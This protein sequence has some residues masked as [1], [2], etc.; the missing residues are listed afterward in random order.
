MKV[1]VLLVSISLLNPLFAK[2]SPLP[3]GSWTDHGLNAAQQNAIRFAFQRGINEQFIPGGSLM[4]IH[5]GEVIMKEG[6]GLA[7]LESKKPFH[8]DAP[9]RIASLTKPHTATMLA[10]LADQGKLSF[11]DPVSKYIPAFKD[12]KV[13]GKSDK[14]KPI[15]L[16]QC[17]SHTAGFASNDQLKAGEFTLNWDGSLKEVVEE[18]ATH[19]LF[20]EPATQY[21][22]GRLGY[23]TAARV[24]EIATG[25]RYETIMDELLF[26]PIGATA[27]NFDYESRIEE[28]PTP[29]VRSK[30]GLV[31][32]TGE[33]EGT[34]INPGGSLITNMDGVARLL[35]LH[36]NR[37]KVDGREI[38]SPEV[39]KQMYVSQPGRGKATYGFGF[40]IM[41]QRADGSSRRIQHTGAAG[42]IGI[43][44]FD[45]DLIV[46]VFTQVPQIQ[47]NQW[48]GPLL[49][50]IFETFEG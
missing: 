17:L 40:N 16:A 21:G 43:V 34:V 49:K 47:T 39:L 6:F 36:R 26:K 12:M 5:E 24:A 37:G 32:R 15:T 30:N 31:I 25:K 11:T 42:T 27:S 44:D 45:L 14:A 46:I 38:V 3:E 7:D 10:I 22:Y 18:L 8:P 50:T 29:Y 13:R 1:A 33:R 28:I 48:R 23:M 20:Y 4:I 2:V 9:C 19:A 35:M 41:K